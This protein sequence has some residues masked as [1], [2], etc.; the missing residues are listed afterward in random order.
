MKRDDLEPD[1]SAYLD[2]ELPPE[3]AAQIRA[4]LEHDPELQELAARHVAAD[5]LLDELPV[6]SLPA[7]LAERVVGAVHDQ[8]TSRRWPVTVTAGVAAA[9]IAT[10]LLWPNDHASDG[11]AAPES[12][13]PPPLVAD[14]EDL[15]RAWRTIHFIEQE[16][17]F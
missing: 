3:H 2:G 4:A 10:W 17:G 16:W 1:L 11:L 12:L 8:P 5:Q 14:A 7:R 13:A 15:D 6:A 9:V